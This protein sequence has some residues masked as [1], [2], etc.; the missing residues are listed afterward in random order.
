MSRTATVVT[1]ELAAYIRSVS[2][3]EPELLAR[4]RDETAGHPQASCQISADQGQFLQ[5]LIRLL[6]ARR[7][8]EVGVFTGYSSLWVA[9]ALPPDG[10]IVA[11]DVSDEYTRV[12]RR[13]WQEAGVKNKIDL[14]LAPAVET[15]EALLTA[16]EAGTYDFAFIDAD[17]RNYLAYYDRCLELIRP[18]GIIAIDNVLW[19]ARVIDADNNDPDTLAVRHFNRALHTDDRVW[20]SLVT[21]GDGLTL[22][23]KK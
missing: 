12:A 11:C 7:T 23:M 2:Q 22:A 4:L 18:G 17:K 13:Y 3:R 9:L 20:I 10:R 6:G 14:R 15:L 5:M 21:M 16:G 1:E 8:I 19:H